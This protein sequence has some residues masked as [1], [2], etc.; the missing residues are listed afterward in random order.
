MLFTWSFVRFLN[1][2]PKG[3]PRSRKGNGTTAKKGHDEPAAATRDRDVICVESRIYRGL[4]DRAPPKQRTR[5]RELASQQHTVTVPSLGVHTAS[6][7]EGWI[8]VQVRGIG[9]SR[10]DT[11]KKISKY[12]L[13]R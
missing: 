12:S 10:Q 11:D 6:G 2:I 13:T 8:R 3:L 9:S 5:F 1:R 7:T 4:P